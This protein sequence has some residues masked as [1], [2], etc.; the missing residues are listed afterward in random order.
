MV[1]DLSYYTGPVFDAFLDSKKERILS[2][3][4]YNDLFEAFTGKP[5]TACGFAINLTLLSQE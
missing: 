5:C 1:S 4:V 2:G 3:G